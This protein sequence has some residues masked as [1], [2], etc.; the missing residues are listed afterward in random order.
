MAVVKQGKLL[1]VIL[2]I[3]LPR[4]LSV[5]LNPIEVGVLTGLIMWGLTLALAYQNNKLLRQLVWL[6]TPRI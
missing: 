1:R 4:P 2:G 3:F 6:H 5:W